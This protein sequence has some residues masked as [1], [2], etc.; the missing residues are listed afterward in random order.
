M[1]IQVNESGT[2]KTTAALSNA[3]VDLLGDGDG[4]FLNGNTNIPGYGYS[5]IVSYTCPFTPSIVIYIGY[6][7]KAV[8][9]SSG[10]TTL[11]AC[12]ILQGGSLSTGSNSGYFNNATTISLTNDQ[13]IFQSSSN[14][15]TPKPSGLIIGTT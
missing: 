5:R 7:S 8:G 2:L 10:D 4:W 6:R 11:Q 12:R 15:L 1:S 14:T 3:F 9:G 13:L